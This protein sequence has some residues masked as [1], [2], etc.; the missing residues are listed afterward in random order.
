MEDFFTWPVIRKMIISVKCMMPLEQRPAL[1]LYHET[2]I[3]VEYI[4]KTLLR[5]ARTLPMSF[6][7][8]QA[9]NFRL[10]L[11]RGPRRE[12]DQWILTLVRE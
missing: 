12:Y 6:C 3:K 8:G 2:G 9:L 7:P 11:N 5:Q 4:C 1:T 10:V